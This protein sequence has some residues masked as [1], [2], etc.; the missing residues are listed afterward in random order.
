MEAS[1]HGLDQHRLDGVRVTVGGFTNLSRD[2]LD[3][4]PTDRGLSRRQAAPVRAHRRAGRR[5]GD[6]GRPRACRHGDRRGARRAACACSRSGARATGIRLIDADDRRLLADAARSSMTGSAYRVRLPLVG[7]FQ[8]ENALVA[9]GLAIATGSDPARGV[10]RARRPRGRQGPARAGRRSATARRSSSTTRTSP[11][12]SPRRSRRCGPTPSAS[13]SSCSARRRPR[14]GQAAADGRDRG[15][16]GRPRHRH[17]RQSAQRESG[18][19]PRRD[20]GG[21]ARRDRDRRPRR[22]DPHARS[23]RLQPGDVLLVAG[24][25]HESGQIVGD[26]VLPFS[27]HEAVAAALEGEGRVSEPLWTVDAMAAAMRAARAG[28]LPARGRRALDRHPHDQAGRGLLRH[29]GR[30]PRRPRLRRRPRCKAGAGLAVVAAGKRAAMPQD[31]PLLVVPDV[32][33]ALERPRRA[34]R[35]RARSAQ[36]RRRHRLGRQ[37]RH[38]GG[39]AARAR[40]ARR[41]ACVGRLLQQSLGRAA[42]ARAHAGERRSSAC[43]RSA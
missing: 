41:D 42:V 40:P 6:R 13:S 9:A 19:D 30:E 12:R 15:R 32:L 8:V 23:R 25:G 29:P 2:H 36:D 20:P 35:A 21:G 39:A 1:S 16:E 4:H 10:R 31:A 7:A 33:A 26:R 18:R 43:S 11:M 3:Y 14:P 28:A 24:K 27:D 38:Q 22:G 17:R 5:R 37:D 34:R